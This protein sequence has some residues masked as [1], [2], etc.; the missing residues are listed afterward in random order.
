MTTATA[1]RTFTQRVGYLIPCVL[2]ADVLSAE[3]IDA[4]DTSSLRTE[5]SQDCLSYFQ[6]MRPLEDGIYL[7]RVAAS[8]ERVAHGYTVLLTEQDLYGAL[9]WDQR[10][11]DKKQCPAS[12][13]AQLRAHAAEIQPL[14]KKT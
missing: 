7:A 14:T 6:V 9:P 12:I 10:L 4:E 2:P 8:P 11:A 3:S 13:L 1:Q 5:A